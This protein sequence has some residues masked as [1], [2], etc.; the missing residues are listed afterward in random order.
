MEAKELQVTNIKKEIIQP[1]TSANHF[2]QEYP[3]LDIKAEVTCG[4]F[5]KLFFFSCS[6]GLLEQIHKQEVLVS[7]SQKSSLYV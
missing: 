5:T 3:Q 2:A 6:V 1:H 4:Y 7:K